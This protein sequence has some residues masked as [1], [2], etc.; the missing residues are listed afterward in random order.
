MPPMERRYL[1]LYGGPIGDS[2]VGIHVGRT[3]AANMPGA[4]FELVSTRENSFVRELCQ[5]LPFIHYRAVPKESLSSWITIFA[6]MFSRNA[7]FAYEPV[8]TTMSPWWKLILWCARRRSDSVE[9]RYQTRGYERPVPRGVLRR[10]FDCEQESYFETQKTVLEAWGIS[11]KNLPQPSLPLQ[12]APKG[13]PYLLFHFFAGQVR[14]SIPVDHARAILE[15]ARVAYPQ[16]DFVLTCAPNERPR[17][18]RM[19][20][21][22]RDTRI[23]SGHSAHE[24]TALLC[25]ADIVIGTVS[26]IL[27][28]AAHLHRPVVAMLCLTHKRGFSPDFSPES[29]VLAARNECRCRPGDSSD[30]RVMTDEGP[31]YRC[32]YFIKTEEVLEA[33]KKKLPYDTVDL[34]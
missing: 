24:L 5:D 17:A 23:E 12:P 30:C 10:V 34:S 22:I 32:L 3:L 8:A 28:I 2:L 16:H 21:G 25:G 7:I 13:T 9:L 15:A 26:G 27:L 4:V 14:R 31:V 19:I 1:L 18:E 33:M 6:L 11:A 29:I 20:E